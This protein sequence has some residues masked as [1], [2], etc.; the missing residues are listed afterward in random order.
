MRFL[1]DNGEFGFL[2]S[3]LVGR[4]MFQFR[5]IIAGQIVGDGEPCIL[6]SAMKQ[7]AHLPHLDDERLVSISSDPA[8]VISALNFDEELHDATTLALAESLD[9]W[10]IHGYV[11]KDSAV[12]LAQEY[13]EDA[14]E[15]PL[16]TSI[17]E[18]AE[19]DSIVDVICSYWSVTNKSSK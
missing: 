4:D 2:V 9:R 6:G 16:L 3:P 7:L 13:G 12:M 10:S 19:Y 15:S 18:V 1:T 8:A 11:Y 17:V 5:L 14:T